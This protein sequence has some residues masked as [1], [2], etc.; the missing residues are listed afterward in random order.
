MSNQPA[1]ESPSPALLEFYQTLCV[2]SQVLADAT[3][4][5]YIHFGIVLASINDNTLESQQAPAFRAMDSMGGDPGALLQ[6]AEVLAQ[7]AEFA[8]SKLAEPQEQSR[9]ILLGDNNVH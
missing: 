6:F 1:T 2:A 4:V 3:G 5:A 8:A 9:I 7:A